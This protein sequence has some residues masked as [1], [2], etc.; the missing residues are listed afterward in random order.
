M[1]E[2]CWS[3]HSLQRFL[4]F[5]DRTG[6][7]QWRKK[8]SMRVRKRLSQSVNDKNGLERMSCV[9]TRGKREAFALGSPS[10]LFLV[11]LFCRGKAGKNEIL[12][13]ENV[14]CFWLELREKKRISLRPVFPPSKKQL[15][16]IRF[17]LLSRIE[18][19]LLLLQLSV[20]FFDN[21]FR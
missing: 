17:S 15:R 10:S 18:A 9:I 2:K 8:T 19:T 12:A 11:F 1:D 3:L 21:N 16:I 4:A 6:K 5:F 14:N 20:R 13:G 7:G